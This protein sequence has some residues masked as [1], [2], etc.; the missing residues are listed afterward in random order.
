MVNNVLITAP[1]TYEQQDS[2]VVQ[3]CLGIYRDARE[4]IAKLESIP[5]LKEYQNDDLL[6]DRELESACEV[7]IKYHLTED[8]Y[9]KEMESG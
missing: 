1:M 8:D 6:D 2:I 5:N 7:L 4:R 9:K 3:A